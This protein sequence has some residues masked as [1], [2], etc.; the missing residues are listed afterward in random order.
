MRVGTPGFVPERLIEARAARRILSK[1][2]LATLISVNPSTV[3]RWEDGTSAPDADALAE[4]AAHLHVRRE[5]FLRPV[6]N[7][8]R[9]LFYRTLASTLI[10][11]LNYQESQMRWLQEISSIVEHYVDFPE[12]DLPDVLKGTS[13]KQLRDEDIER[14]ASDL[15]DHWGIGHGPCLDMMPLL[16][17]IGCIVGSIE[18]GT[19]KLD[20]LC[21]WAHGNER[22]HILLSTDKMSFPRRQMDAAHELGHAILHHSVTEDELK[23]DLKEIERQAFR[24]ASAFLLPATTYAYEVK[25]ASL[26]SLLSLKERWRVSVKAQIRRLSDLDLIPEDHATSLYKLYSAKG[27]SRE[28][29]LDREWPISEPTLLTNALQLI[30]NSGV[31]SKSDLL[32][33]E[34][35]MKAGDIEN[36]TALPPGW[37]SKTGE[38]I[39]LKLRDGTSDRNAVGASA[40]LPFSPRRR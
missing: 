32:S 35:T 29:P 37:F 25:N 22:P 31:R 24:F 36:L 14:I 38:L 40:I 15:R 16:E 5:Y 34:F 10:K 3:T 20:G 17:R 27:W 12:V 8:D 18:M 2:A 21:S 28:E 33:V 1:K 23:K 4:L 6:A 19:S 39:G 11:D 13:Y 9:P 26:A 7:S 30:V